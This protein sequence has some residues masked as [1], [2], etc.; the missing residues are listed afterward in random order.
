MTETTTVGRALDQPG[1]VGEHELVFTEAHHTEIWHQRR[2]R[3]IGDLRTRRAHRRD[4][5]RLPRVGEADQRGVGHQLELEPQPVL[6]AVLTLLREARRSSCV[7][8]KAGVAAPTLSTVC[9]EI[10]VAVTHQIGQQLTT[11]VVDNGAFG[12]R[13]S[14]IRARRAVTLVARA[15]CARLR[16]PMWMVAKREQRRGVAIGSQPH[17]ATFSAVPAVGT[18]LGH[19]RLAP[20]RDRARAAV[21]PA[22]VELNLVDELGHAVRIRSEST[23][24]S[25]QIWT[26]GGRRRTRSSPSTC[27]KRRAAL[28]TRSRW[29]GRP[30]KRP[31]CSASRR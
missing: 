2:E 8:E 23:R 15:V 10:P 13:H 19:V 9:C 22:G 28:P 18:T 24:A 6:L 5:R 25:A 30:G 20:E 27:S 14:E 26:G 11:A 4:Q 12:H 21:T 1:D 31:S 3:I 29:T 16:A 17:V 7:G